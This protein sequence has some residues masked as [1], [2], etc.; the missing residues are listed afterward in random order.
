M[1]TVIRSRGAAFRSATYE[2][3]VKWLA[4]DLSEWFIIIDNADDPSLDL[5]PFF[6]K[7]KH[8]HII[9]TSRDSTR[10]ILSPNHSYQIGP[11]APKES[12]DM[13]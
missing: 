9:V 12:I 8:G 11:L 6:P 10:S 7:C 2:D 4:S 13:L 1:E 3:A 5:F